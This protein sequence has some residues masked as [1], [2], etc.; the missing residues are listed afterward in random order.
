MP[1]G[2][3]VEMFAGALTGGGIMLAERG[4]DG[5]TINGLF[6]V[7]FDPE[8]MVDRAYY[9]AEIERFYAYLRAT[10]PAPGV[11]AVLVPGDPE[12]ISLKARTESGV[13]V[14]AVSWAEMCQAARDVGLNDTDIPAT[15]SG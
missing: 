11:D 1:L 9:D 14:D 8:L 6:S 4:G 3:A 5:A 7:I 10:P 2:V 15:K 13:P 12:Q